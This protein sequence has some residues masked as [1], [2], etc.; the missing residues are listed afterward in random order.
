MSGGELVA[1]KGGVAP[2]LEVVQSQLL[3]R[4]SILIDITESESIELFTH[5]GYSRPFDVIAAC[6]PSRY[7]SRGNIHVFKAAKYAQLDKIAGAIQEQQRREAAVQAV[8]R[9]RSGAVLIVREYIAT[10]T[11]CTDLCLTFLKTIDF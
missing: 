6:R 8:A 7:P 4:Q 5:S 11:K 1:D 2:S 3:F 10:L 9:E